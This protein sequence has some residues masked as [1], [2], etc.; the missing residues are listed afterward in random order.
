[1]TTTG[2]QFG[3][4]LPTGP[5]TTST[6]EDIL[7]RTLLRGQCAQAKADLD[8]LWWTLLSPRNVLLYQAAVDLCAGRQSA[9]RVMYDKA[10][11]IGFMV[12]DPDFKTVDCLTYKAVRSVVKQEPQDRIDCVVGQ[13]PGWPPGLYNR[14]GKDDPRTPRNEATDSPTETTTPSTTATTTVEPSTTTSTT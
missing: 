8:R 5:K 4:N 7:Y 12:S 11:R 2:R 1:M 6:N 9:A 13:V 14:E 10:A 3:W